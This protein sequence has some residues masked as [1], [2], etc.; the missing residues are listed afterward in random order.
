M[1][2]ARGETPL[3]CAAS[4]TV[5]ALLESESALDCSSGGSCLIL[6]VTCRGAKRETRTVRVCVP[7][8]CC[9]GLSDRVPRVQDQI[10]WRS[11]QLWPRSPRERFRR[12]RRQQQQRERRNGVNWCWCA[13]NGCSQGPCQA[14]ADFAQ[15]A[16]ASGSRTSSSS[17]NWGRGDW[18]RFCQGDG[19]F[20]FE[21]FVKPSVLELRI[22]VD[23][24]SR[25]GMDLQ[26]KAMQQMQRILRCPASCCGR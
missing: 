18:R 25:H 22:I 10:G 6:P 1:K 20:R 5:R 14:H 9:G 24:I 2:N 16:C 21:C 17:S 4:S 3:D 12:R 8:L 11:F 15:T 13:S 7:L 26:L 23:V 19:H